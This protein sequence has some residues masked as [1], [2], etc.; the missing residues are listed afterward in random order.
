MRIIKNV[1]NLNEEDV[2]NFYNKRAFKYDEKNPY[3]SVMLQ[4]ANPELAIYR[5]RYEKQTILPF[6]NLDKQSKVIDI[7]CGVGRWADLVQAYTDCYYGIDFS[8]EIINIAKERKYRDM[9]KPNYIV[10]SFQ[11]IAFGKSKNLIKDKFNRV[12]IAGVG[13]YINDDELERC[14]N[15]LL[16]IL[17]K[18]TI[19]YIREPIGIEER[20]TLKE[21]YSNEMSLYYN[22][23]YRTKEQYIEMLAKTLCN[24]D[25]FIESE[26]YIITDDTQNRKE[27]TQYYFILKNKECN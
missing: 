15:G 26:G 9:F 17:D 3:L 6:L 12:I 24:K 8:E 21:F 5:D 23:I 20:L 13:I 27:T 14:Y 10:A 4:D 18:D 19:I 2:K 11:D 16:D 7:G 1:V 22:A 25:F